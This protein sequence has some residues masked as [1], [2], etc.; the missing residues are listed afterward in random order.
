MK[1]IIV[2]VICVAALV[3]GILLMGE[4]SAEEIILLPSIDAYEFEFEPTESTAEGEQNRLRVAISEN[5]HFFTD[6][7]AVAVFASNPYAYIYY[8]LDGSVPTRASLRYTEP[9]RM[10]R[11]RQTVALRVIA[12]YDGEYSDVLTHTFFL[13][14]QVHERHNALVFSITTT[15]DY[16]HCFYTGIL[17][18]G[19]QRR[20]WIRENP[21]VN[22]RPPDPANWN[23]R[24][25]EAEVPI[26][27]E[28]FNVYGERV[29]NQRAGLRAHGRWSRAYD[30]TSLRLI[31]RRY[32]EPELGSF[33]YQFFPEVELMRYDQLILRNGGNDRN[34]GMLRNEVGSLLAAQAGFDV[35]TPVRA[36]AVYVNGRFY[37]FAWLNVRIN[38]RWLQ[39]IFEAPTRDFDIIG[40]GEHWLI[41][42]EYCE[43]E[44]QA[45]RDLRHLNS[46]QYRDLTCDITFAELQA[47][48][49]MDNLMFY[50]AFQIFM[51][52]EDWPHNNL[53]RWRYR[54]PQFDGMSEQLG[55]RWRF[56]FFDLDWTLGLYGDNYAKPTF[57]NTLVGQDGGH[58]RSRLMAAILQR[59]DMA[60]KFTMVMNDIAANVVTEQT[61]LDA[62]GHLM[63]QSHHEITR[64]LEAGKYNHWVS[65]WSIGENHMNMMNFARGRAERI[66]QNLSV[67]FGVQRNFFDV[68]VT[69][70]YAV[71]GTIRATSSRYFAHLVVPVT[72]ILPQWTA[73]C[74]W[75][76]NGQRVEHQRVYVTA[77]DAMGGVVSLTLH[78]R[79]DLPP[80]KFLYTYGNGLV[81]FNPNDEPIRTVGLYLSNNRDNLH[82]WPIPAA[83]IP[84]RGYM[85][86]AGEDSRDPADVGRVR[87][88]FNVRPGRRIYLSDADGIV[89]RIMP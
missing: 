45:Y 36:A 89:D 4:G 5:E 15:E 62:I 61:V 85:E 12:Y 83:V 64:A 50:Y 78:T 53:R 34:F 47:L 46:F 69:G 30:Q 18:A 11:Y 7:I 25:R 37:G 38:E 81:L 66:E 72:P 40:N 77:A 27:L 17:V 6:D 88:P 74:H 26:G 22:P 67:F 39:D 43:Y 28:V 71:I 35:V 70:G 56:A 1:K 86:M 84:P 13:G 29:I 58:P 68:E 60:R 8:T 19:V 31:A 3:G 9:I 41:A 59:D 44:Q 32:Y 79:P 24:G 76:K 73:F 10:H 82:R 20:D 65:W 55:G 23:M 14:R 75:E 57:R 2:L 48:V 52:A 21:G 42:D 51:G 54:G 63:A 33:H 49:C 87:M 16:L 80:L